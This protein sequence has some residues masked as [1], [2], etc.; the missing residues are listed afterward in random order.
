MKITY[1]H[2][3]QVD[4]I[5]V[6][7][8]TAV[9][10]PYRWLENPTSADTQA[11]VAAQN[12]LTRAFIDSVPQRPAIHQ[13]LTELWNYPRQFA[14]QR[15]GD[16]LFFY[17]N[18][19]L[20]NQAVLYRA[21][22]L[23]EAPQ[24]A[25][26]PNTLAEDGTAAVTSQ[27][28]TQDGRFLAY[29]VSYGGSDQQEIYVRDLESNQ[30]LPD[31]L[32]HCRFASIAW[33]YDAA[34]APL[35]FYYNRDPERDPARPDAP[36]QDN[37]LYWHTL[38]TPQ[39]QDQLIYARPDAPE[40]KFPPMMSEDGRYLILYVW[41]AAI[42]RN[43]LYYRVE[44]TPGSAG[45]FVRLIDE[46]DAAYHFIG[47]VGDTFYI[48]TDWQAPNGR[49]MAIDLAQP[50]REQW[51]EIVPE[52]PDVLVSASMAGG[53]LA[54]VTMHNATHRLSLYELDGR[55]A[56]QPSLPEMGAISGLWGKAGSSDLFFKF[57][58]YLEP[59]SIYR[60][61]IPTAQLT[62][63]WQ[64]PLAYDPSRY[65]TR[66]VFYPSKDGTAVSMFLVHQ[67]GLR[68][69]GSHP[70]LLYG[71]GGYSISHLPTFA[72]QQLYWVEQGG[73]FVDVNL[74]GG[75]EYGES[76]HRAGMLANKQNVFDD[77]IA[78]AEW[79][80]ANGYTQ[81]ERLAIMG[82]SN[83]GLLT[84]AVMLQRPDLFGAVLAIVPVT[85]MLRFHKFTA[86]RYWT[87]EYGNAEEN[88]DHF[89]FL[90]A[91]SPLHNVRQGTRYPATLITTADGDDRVVPL[92]AYKF[93]A[94][95]QTAVA[96][97]PNAAPI[98]LR[99]DMKSGHGLGK[100]TYKWLD[101]WADIFAFLQ[102]TLQREH[103]ISSGQTGH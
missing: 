98:L 75:S 88:A 23:D 80:I 33:V 43:R 15:Y 45:A 39:E 59:G 37:K 96:T 79:L 95:L 22:S 84:A 90:Y 82:R 55:L 74:R 21:H 54:V 78:A 60:Y 30:E 65:E 13:R 50:Q 20:Q 85:D 56:A 66:Q 87:A 49:I 38:G 4:V 1:P 6:Y 86:G 89:R 67:K 69:D 62:A 92:H 100:P 91:Y 18:D 68:L 81:P 46:P 47:N 28:V 10:D 14:P 63:V 102:A 3:P 94:A 41:H 48:Q 70:V 76:W 83:G 16:W 61:D 27:A 64:T 9:A 51:R 2:T 52:Q 93:A 77:F 8:G 97:V 12:Q 71:Y 25:L 29:G 58:T 11:W 7:H 34:G 99:V 101:E 26:D 73:V 103:A 5:E 35:G 53:K 36:P 40:L 57:E 42:S 72:P 31:R 32:R 24:I 17:H 44:E 19:G